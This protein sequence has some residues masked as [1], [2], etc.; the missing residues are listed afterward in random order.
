M[1][2]SPARHGARP[3][4]RPARRDLLCRTAL[5]GALMGFVAVASPSFAVPA[6]TGQSQVNPGGTLPTIRAGCRPLLSPT[7]WRHRWAAHTDRAK[8]NICSRFADR[9]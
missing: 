7:A 8:A 3:A 9:G 4:P 6:W 2:S 5:C 1:T